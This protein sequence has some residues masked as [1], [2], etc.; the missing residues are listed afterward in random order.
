MKPMGRSLVCLLLAVVLSV[1]GV[2]QQ[3]REQEA[4]FR[5]RVDVVE[6][7][8]TALDSLGQTIFDL[9]GKEF[10][11]NDNG[12]P[13]R[14]LDAELSP[15]PVS[16]VVLV[17]A[18]S[19]V[20]PLLDRVRN[21]GILFSEVVMGQ[22]GEGAIMAFDSGLHLLQNFTL[23]GDKIITALKKIRAGDDGARL[24]DALGRAVEMLS[25]REN[26]RRVIIAI[27]EPDDRGSLIKI[28]EPLRDAQLANV[29]IYTIGLNTT[30]AMLMQKDTRP[31]AS[32]FP[33]GVMARPLPPG[34]VP[35]PT[36]EETYYGGVNLMPAVMMLVQTLS[37]SLGQNPLKVI[38][39]GTGASYRGQ[40][41]KSGLEEA[42]SQ[43][44]NEI[45]SQYVLSYRPTNARESGFHRIEVRAKRAG[46]SVR[47]RPGYFIGP[48]S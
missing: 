31:P 7:P 29:S 41:T 32:P 48:A 46:V 22:T 27:T 26:R 24:A 39:A 12:I 2:A 47:A 23:D 8:V 13:Q 5:V 43:V 9:D 45:H 38:A 25:T 30:Q 3:N 36:A 6:V 18:S 34:V 11:L 37:N 14:I 1:P 42:I 21:T 28:G 35:T 20:G 40:L 10:E 4:H 19:R 15:Q 17:D 33:P 16:L 44:G